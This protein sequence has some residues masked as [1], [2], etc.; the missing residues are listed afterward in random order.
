MLLNSHENH[1]RQTP[2]CRLST[3]S[4]RQD[5]VAKVGKNWQISVILVRNLL[6]QMHYSGFYELF[7]C[8]IVSYCI[9]QIDKASQLWFT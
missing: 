9:Y 7:Q 5:A 1:F 6:K 2:R 4:N 8:F 3:K